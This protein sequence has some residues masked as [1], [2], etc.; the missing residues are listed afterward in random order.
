MGAFIRI[1]WYCFSKGVDFLKEGNK[2]IFF[3]KSYASSSWLKC[4]DD[5]CPYKMYIEM[6][7]RGS[8]WIIIYI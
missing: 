1:F 6:E 7:T 3:F 2:E 5:V 4:D 8:I